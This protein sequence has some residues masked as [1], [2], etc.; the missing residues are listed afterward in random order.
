[1]KVPSALI[2]GE[3]NYLINP[4]HKDFSKI[5]IINKESFNFDARMFLWNNKIIFIFLLSHFKTMNLKNKITNQ[6]SKAVKTVFDYDLA[7]KITSK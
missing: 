6:I 2:N 5:M 4:K 1:M 7:E 3:F